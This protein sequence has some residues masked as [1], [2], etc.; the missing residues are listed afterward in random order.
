MEMGAEWVEEM[1]A[2]WEKRLVVARKRVDGVE[3]LGVVP[4]V[5]LSTTHIR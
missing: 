1:D 2:W 5:G 4:G 3:E